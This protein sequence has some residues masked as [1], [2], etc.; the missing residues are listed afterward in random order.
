MDTLQADI[1]KYQELYDDNIRWRQTQ[2]TGVSEMQ[3]KLSKAEAAL[4]QDP[5]LDPGTTT[6]PPGVDL[7]DYVTRAD[8]EKSLQE[9]LGET[10]RNGI[11]LMA[12]ISNIQA[13]HL[14][15]FG[16]ALD[17]QELF[18]HATKVSLPLPAAYQDFV[19]ERVEDAREKTHKEE[20]TQAREE[21]RLEALR[22]PMLP[23]NVS[24]NEPTVLD[25]LGMKD[26][27]E[28]GLTKAVDDY[29][30]MQTKKQAAS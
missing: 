30:Q 5:L 28:F 6:P 22:T 23:H 9:R 4:L 18:E 13:R 20:V 15:D 17:A 21:G 14:K 10:E 27:S 16:E 2:E 12:M 19:K 24:N 25:V 3:T 1:D 11:R 26:R 29:W 7:S 8:A